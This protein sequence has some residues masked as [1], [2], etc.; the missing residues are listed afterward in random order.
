MSY[1]SL[2]QRIQFFDSSAFLIL[3]RAP[4]TL[5]G[6]GKTRCRSNISNTIQ[7]AEVTPASSCAHPVASSSLQTTINMTQG[8][9]TTSKVQLLDGCKYYQV[10]TEA[11]RSAT[12]SD[13]SPMRCD[14]E[15]HGWYRFAGQAGNRMSNFCP[16]SGTSAYKCGSYYQGWI[17]SGA[18][19]TV[20]QGLLGL[21]T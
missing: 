18:L 7:S 17:P 11:N 16:N 1:N 2:K 21:S 20:Y 9:H 8:V 13:W 3:A 6:G 12:Y 19:P 4:V 15:L 10:L 14:Q 5:Y